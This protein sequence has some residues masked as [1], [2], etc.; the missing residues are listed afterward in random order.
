M[1][2]KVTQSCPTLVTPWTVA[3]QLPLSKGFSR[4]EYWGGLP[5]PSPGNAGDL[6]SIPWLGRYP[7]EGKGFPLQDFGLENSMDCIVRGVAKSQTQLSDLH[8]IS[9]MC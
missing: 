2:V 9:S 5:F 4:Q 7:G 6:G 8:F 3:R 1:N